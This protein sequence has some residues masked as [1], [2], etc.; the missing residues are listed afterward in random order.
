MPN[1]YIVY[2]SYFHSPFHSCL[3]CYA[4]VFYKCCF[5]Y[6]NAYWCSWF[7]LLNLVIVST[8]WCNILLGW[9]SLAEWILS[10]EVLG[11]LVAE[12]STEIDLSSRLLQEGAKALREVGQLEV[13]D[14]ILGEL[15]KVLKPGRDDQWLTVGSFRRTTFCGNVWINWGN[16][17][18]GSSFW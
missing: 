15:G 17:S 10:L 12:A 1:T 14:N 18:A 8:V 5:L 11:L 3:A 2:Q 9:L 6:L 4:N 16:L 13:G 7:S